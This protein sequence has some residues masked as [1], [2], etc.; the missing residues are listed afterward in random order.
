MLHPSVHLPSW[1]PAGFGGRPGR[2][3]PQRRLSCANG[4]HRIDPRGQER[5]DGS[6]RWVR[7]PPMRIAD[8]LKSPISD[9]EPARPGLGS[10]VGLIYVVAILAILGFALVYDVGTG[11]P[12]DRVRPGMTQTEVARLLGVPQQ[13]TRFGPV[14]RQSWRE[15]GGSWVDLEFREGKLVTTR[16]RPP[17][18]RD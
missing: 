5:L 8:G 2:G 3:I 16:R 10:V 6:M 17:P 15:P 18:A 11:S 13:E 14:L 9:S 7:T 4:G 1:V 12:F